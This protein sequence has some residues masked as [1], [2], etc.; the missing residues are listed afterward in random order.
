MQKVWGSSAFAK[1]GCYGRKFCPPTT[2]SHRTPQRNY[3]LFGGLSD[4]SKANRKA[5]MQFLA[6]VHPMDLQRLII[7]T[8]NIDKAIRGLDSEVIRMIVKKVPNPDVLMSHLK[9]QT[10]QFITAQLCGKVQKCY[11]VGRKKSCNSRGRCS[12]L[13]P[14]WVAMD[15][16]RGHHALVPMNFM[17]D[18]NVPMHVMP[19]GGRMYFY[20]EPK[21]YNPLTGS[22][23]PVVDPPYFLLYPTIVQ[24]M[25][26]AVL[27]SML[28]S[29]PNLRQLLMSV[30]PAQLQYALA[31]VPAFGD[32][33]ASMDPYD[34]QA[35]IAWMP[36]V[37]DVVAS[38]DP[39]LL[40][41][42][43]ASVPNIDSI[44]FG[45]DPY[46]GGGKVS[47]A[48][49]QKHARRKSST[50]KQEPVAKPSKPTTMSTTTDTTPTTTTTTTAPTTAS[51]TAK[52]IATTSA[53]T[54]TTSEPTATT[55]QPSTGAPD[56]PN[57]MD[58]NVT[59]S[60]LSSVPSIPPQYAN[61]LL[62]MQPRFVEYVVEE[63]EDLAALLTNMSAQTL[64]YVT[65]HVPQ[66][67]ALLSNLSSTTL[68]AV[69]DKLSDD[70]IVEYL[71]GVDDEVVRALVAK[72]PSLAKYA[73]VEAKMTAPPLEETEGEEEEE[74]EHEQ[75]EEEDEEEEGKEREKEESGH[76]QKEEEPENAGRV[77]RRMIRS[78]DM[79]KRRGRRRNLNM[80]RGEIRRRWGK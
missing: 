33:A 9:P 61:I 55:S 41:S 50:V 74:S 65:E 16:V 8:P 77:R 37:T 29:M 70:D 13:G 39:S 1:R 28:L 7:S 51:T 76:E 30:D 46:V 59:Q 71:G 40:Q 35:M 69:L 60:I 44:V 17:Q 72:V 53:P 18:S 6:D 36:E 47:H 58:A 19:D 68:E 2:A 11:P 63:H 62:N 26:P 38:M 4:K 24:A 3:A 73:P 64:H 45:A 42:I 20:K 31:Y 80:N 22:V 78:M 15:E 14:E 48:R 10:R 52:T 54:S 32:Y 27:Q 49:S 21:T 25:D 43:I 23:E 67:G 66:F 5:I 79:R 57:P 34:L 12:D 75:G 56:S